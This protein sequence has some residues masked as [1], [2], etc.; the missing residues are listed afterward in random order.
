MQGCICYRTTTHG[1]PYQQPR[2]VCPKNIDNLQ[3][4]AFRFEPLVSLQ[5]RLV[6]ARGR[7]EYTWPLKWLKIRYITEVGLLPANGLGTQSASRLK[8]NGRY[9][10]TSHEADIVMIAHHA[11]KYSKTAASTA[12]GC[13]DRCFC[14]ASEVHPTLDPWSST[15]VAAKTTR[16]SGA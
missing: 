4:F 8:H 12:A 7:P 1:T 9:G 5:S 2:V 3:E 15:P 14:G 10:A 11:T 6:Q 16:A 13:A